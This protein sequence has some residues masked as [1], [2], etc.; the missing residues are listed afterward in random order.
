MRKQTIEVG[1]KTAEHTDTAANDWIDLERVAAVEISSEEQRCPIERALGMGADR[2]VSTGWRAATTGPQTIRLR[3]DR[4]TEI[5]RIYLHFVEGAAERSQEFTVYAGSSEGELR[6]VVRQQFAFSP[7]G[8]TEEVEDYRVELKN[9]RV[10][11]LRV[12]PDRAHDA[13]QS[14]EYASLVRMKV[15]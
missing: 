14:R 1:A 10:F 13:K 4:P 7:G 11:E 5:R 12:D 15:A 9:V 2:E 8:A 6:E 3:F